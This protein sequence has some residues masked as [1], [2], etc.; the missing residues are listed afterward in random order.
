MT[1][2]TADL[3]YSPASI[4]SV[5]KLPFIQK[6]LTQKPICTYLELQTIVV[7]AALNL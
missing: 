5:E 7:C 4:N 3:G 2:V 1:T 6:T